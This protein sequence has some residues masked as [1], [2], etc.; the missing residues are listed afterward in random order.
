MLKTLVVALLMTASAAVGQVIESPAGCIAQGGNAVC[1]L[2][3]PNGNTVQTL[4]DGTTWATVLP[5]T[6]RQ[7]S[8]LMHPSAP[9]FRTI[10]I[11]NRDTDIANGPLSDKIQIEGDCAAHT[12]EIMGNEGMSGL[13]GTGYSMED[14][15][16]SELTD[17][18]GGRVIRKAL[19]GSNVEIAFKLMCAQ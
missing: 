7:V 11:A 1:K 14:V 18:Q 15:G 6:Q 12:Y 5:R 8:V 2:T 17:A 4:A 19:P 13:N 10:L 16:W 9:T 3:Y